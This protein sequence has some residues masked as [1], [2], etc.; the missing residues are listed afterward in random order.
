MPAPAQ[1][2]LASLVGTNGNDS[3]V[4]LIGGS[5]I[6]GLLGNDTLVGLA[7]NDALVGDIGTDLLLGALGDDSLWGGDGAD[8][9]D[10]S[11]GNDMLAAGAGADSAFG[12][13]GDDTVWGVAGVSS[14]TLAGGDGNDAISG[15]GML[16][17]G[18]GADSLAGS[19]GA[20]TLDGGDGLDTMEGGSGD[21][22]YIVDDMGDRVIE[23]N[24]TGFDVVFASVSYD[25]TNRV[26][27]RLVLT[28][29]GATSA[30]G[31]PL[32]NELV[33]NAG[34]N[35]LVGL[36]GADTLDG[37]A[38]ADTLEGG[39][40]NDVYIVDHPG[41]LVIEASG[42]GLDLVLASITFDMSGQFA[43]RLVLTGIAAINGF[44]NALANELVGNGAANRLQGREGADTLDGGA[45]ADTL[46]GGTGNDTYVV[47]NAG[48]RVIEAA[49]EGFDQVFAAVTFSLNGQFAE[50]LVLTGAAAINGTG[51]ALANQLVGNGAANRLDG[52]GG[53]D[54]MEGGAGNDTYVVDNAG[55]R[56][57]ED[58]G[59][60]TDL[61]LASVSYALGGQAIENLR[62]TGLDAINGEGND[63]ANVLDGN[64][65]GN[66]LV[67]GVGNDSLFGRGGDDTLEP[68]TGTDRMGGGT[69]N[70][71]YRVAAAELTS[72][73]LIADDAGSADTIEILDGLDPIAPDSFQA[74]NIGGS[75]ANRIQGIER[76]VL[77]S[78]N[79]T[80]LPGNL[81]GDTAD[82]DVVSAW[83]GAGADRLDG[84]QVSRLTAPLSFLLDGGEGADTLVGGRGTDTLILGAGADR[85]SGGLGN[86]VFLVD[87]AEL[88]GADILAGESGT[89]TLRFT[90]GGAVGAGAFAGLSGI[91]VIELSADG[92]EMTLPAAFADGLGFTMGTLRGGDGD[93]VIDVSAFAANRRVTVELGAGNDILIGGAGNDSVFAGGG[94]DE[95]HVDAGINRV[96]F[97]VDELSALDIVTA[98][99]AIAFDTLVVGVA[100][101]RTLAQTVFAGVSGFDTFNLNGGEGSAARLPATLVT[102]SG[103]SSVNVNVTGGSMA[104]DARAVASGIRMDG[105]AGNDTVFG[106]SGADT[107]VG[108]G[109]DDVH[110]GGTGG[111]RIFLGTSVTSRDIALLRAASDGTADINTAVSIAGADSVSGTEFDGNFIMADR[112]AFGLADATTWFVGAAQNISL[113]YSAA[114]LE[115]VSVAAD[116]F[117]SLTAVRAAV[118]SRLTNNDPLQ[119]E[120]LLLVIT[121]ASNTRFG[122]YFFQDRDHNATVDSTDIL[123]LLAVGTGAGPT[124]SGNS[125]FRLTSE[126]ELLG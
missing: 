24:V 90:G 69:G 32:A 106:G 66:L 42:A 34:Q 87:A 96:T 13:D 79:D 60:G 105:G 41:D 14:A 53:A 28:G 74:I 9:L 125:G 107:L 4:A 56:V 2:I 8:T 78:G 91:E 21:D 115:G 123:R 46:E 121:G 71:L 20:D 35:L 62:L 95:I 17:G 33:G 119:F 89:D 54:T 101:G 3:L 124:F 1:P 58:P 61:V 47:D 76:F 63:L 72:A 39:T 6:A 7:A 27:E 19:T 97:G 81:I 92:Q 68:G 82:A 52:L 118:G 43:E 117:G 86:D 50:R 64:A 22:V 57:V 80:F 59:N 108:N 102:Q 25:L 16:L 44:G 113:D 45:G 116:D 75:L 29:I 111:D 70:D 109:G 99:T 10:G 110:V 65:A 94:V 26:V 104:V 73:D 12:G 15:G 88:T 37:G 5:T 30:T 36:G 122:V 55:D 126:F 120:S 67:G 114:R 11:T 93:D 49:G 83:G 48:D 31:N 112:F 51:N 77:G 98:A 103:Q 100:A 84:S 23:A 38:G 40:G 85:A 18:L